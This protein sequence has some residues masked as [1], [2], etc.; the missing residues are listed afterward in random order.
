M[1]LLKPKI[2]KKFIGFFKHG[3]VTQCSYTT[4]PIKVV[5]NNNEK[6]NFAMMEK[7]KSM[8]DV[9]TQ[10]ACRVYDV[11]YV[12]EFV[13]KSVQERISLVLLSLISF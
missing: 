4:N 5:E 8:I 9:I 2:R 10:V 13:V 11:D 7:D 3:I 12:N 1:E 6:N